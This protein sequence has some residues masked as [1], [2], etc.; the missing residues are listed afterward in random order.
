[1]SFSAA[2][3]RLPTGSESVDGNEPMGKE[4][5]LQ[6]EPIVRLL[7]D[8]RLDLTWSTDAQ[9]RQ[10]ALSTSFGNSENVDFRKTP[11]Q[12]PDFASL[13]PTLHPLREWEGFVVGI[14][15][16]TFEARILDVAAG[17]RYDS[18]EATIPLQEIAHGD[19]ERIGIGS[20][21]RWVIGHE[22]SPA[23]SKRRVSQIVFRDLPAVTSTDEHDGSEWAREVMDKFGL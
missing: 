12:R 3:E 4:A 2:A 22:R 7:E 18:A 6:S 9:P 20:V 17:D 13:Q 15:S 1:M 11:A 14:G 5:R 21:F 16:E 19:R 23:G 10:S 8:L